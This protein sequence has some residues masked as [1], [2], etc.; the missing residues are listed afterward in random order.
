MGGRSGFK[1]LDHRRAVIPVQA[2]ATI[3]DHVADQRRQRDEA[4]VGE[5]DLI[6]EGLV[7]GDDLVVDGLVVIHEI[8]LVHGDHHVG[9][10]H[11]LGQV[12]VT[13]GLGEHALARVDQDDRDVGGG[14]G[15]HHVAGVLLVARRVGDD[16]LA[17][18]G[19][20]VAVGHVD[21]D[22]LL[23]L[24]LQTV[25]KQRQIDCGQAALVGGLL[26]GGEG[27]G[28]D[29][30]GV[31]Q[32]AADQGALAVIDGAAGEEAQQA[33]VDVGQFF[34]CGHGSVFLGF[35]GVDQK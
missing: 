7:L 20:E 12:A 15:G 19:R 27:V 14:C 3:H 29:G 2:F 35:R 5:A 11:E 17:G 22:A 10:A 31:E 32:Q 21:G 28:Q 13:T 16:V 8:H 9:D 24:G 30:L 4:N 26:D 1:D 25:G 23:A 6:G 18:A 33:V 34:G